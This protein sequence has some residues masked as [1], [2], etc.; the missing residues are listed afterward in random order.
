[1]ESPWKGDTR[2]P[3]LGKLYPERLYRK[4]PEEPNDYTY[5]ESLNYKKVLYF[6][7]LPSLMRWRADI[8]QTILIPAVLYFI[9]P[10]WQRCLNYLAMNTRLVLA[11]AGWTRWVEA[12]A[13]LALFPRSA[14]FRDAEKRQFQRQQSSPN[15][16][17]QFRIWGA[18]HGTPQ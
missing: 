8:K 10:I 1:M 13:P 5:K 17:I 9:F 12:N 3:N 4:A 18:I 6:T 15:C 11:E 16:I 2:A 7:E 14:G